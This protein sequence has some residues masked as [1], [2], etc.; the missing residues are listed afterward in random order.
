VI[1]R[2]VPD[3]LTTTNPLGEFGALMVAPSGVW[4]PALT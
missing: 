3:A 1:G 2:F 4:L